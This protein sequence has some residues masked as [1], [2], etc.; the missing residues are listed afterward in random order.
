MS[1]YGV[2]AQNEDEDGHISGVHDPSG[3]HAVLD[4]AGHFI[5]SNRSTS[6]FA[7][8]QQSGF[9]SSGHLDANGPWTSTQG[10]GSDTLAGTFKF[11]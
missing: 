10:Q 11:A 5:S 8:Q 7:A 3:E 2:L 9:G 4:T 6:A 1:Q